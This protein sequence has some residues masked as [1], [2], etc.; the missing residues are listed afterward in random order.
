MLGPHE[1]RLG[2]RG[3]SGKGDAEKKERRPFLTLEGAGPVEISGLSTHERLTNRK[4]CVPCNLKLENMRAF[5]SEAMVLPTVAT[6][7]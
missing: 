2:V 1:R 3:S 7:Q 6:P 5:K 4:V